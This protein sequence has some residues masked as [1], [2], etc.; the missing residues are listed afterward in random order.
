MALIKCPDCKKKISDSVEKCPK[1][2][3]KLSEDMIIEAKNKKERGRKKKRVII[4]FSLIFTFLIVV[5]LTTAYFVNENNKKIEEEKRIEKKKEEEEQRKKKKADEKTKKRKLKR[6]FYQ[7]TIALNSSSNKMSEYL[8]EKSVI[9]SNTWSNAIFKSK[10]K[11]TNKYTIEKGKFVDFN[12]AVNN[13][14]EDIFEKKQFEKIYQEYEKEKSD[15]KVSCKN[16][17]IKNEYRELIKS[18]TK[19]LNC[20]DSYMNALMQPSGNYDTFVE[21][22]NN[23]MQ[24]EENSVIEATNEFTSAGF[25]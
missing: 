22:I 23:L 6:E 16:D 12:K 24:D 17:F 15:W 1:C 21:N 8:Q 18:E 13:A 10:N 19:V 7:K 11:D 14:I 9:I 20:I 25:Y 2:G 5:G 3:C 4:I